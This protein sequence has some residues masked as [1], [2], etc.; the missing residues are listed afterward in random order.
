MPLVKIEI[1]ITVDRDG[2]SA[3]AALEREVDPLLQKTASKCGPELLAHGVLDYMTRPVAV[4]GGDKRAQMT[5][6]AAPEI[7]R[8][9]FP[10]A[11]RRGH[12]I[13]GAPLCQHD[14]AKMTQ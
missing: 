7:K 4:R 2:H 9:A 3:L 8:A 5:G 11:A 10:G 1:A 14:R 12:F 13:G 6:C